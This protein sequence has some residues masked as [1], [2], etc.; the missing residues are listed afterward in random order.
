[1][2]SSDEIAD[3]NI[4]LRRSTKDRLAKYRQGGSWSDAVDRVIEEA[5]HGR[6]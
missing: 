6:E 1:M 5:E 3:Q 4:A 2:M